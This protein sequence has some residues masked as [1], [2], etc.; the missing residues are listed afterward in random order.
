MIGEPTAEQQ[1]VIDASIDAGTLVLAGPGTGKTHTLILRLERMVAEERQP[2]VLS[3]TRSVVRE[4]H[5]RLGAAGLAARYLRPVTFDSM[6]TR[7]LSSVPELAGW[8]GWES[9]GYEGRIAAAEA[10]IEQEPAAR[11]WLASRFDHVVVDEVQDL[12]GR[13]GRLVLKILEVMPG[14]TL[15]GDPAQGIYGWQEDTEGLSADDFLAAVHLQH[16]QCLGTYE[17]TKNHRAQTVEIRELADYRPGL[18]DL[19]HA[20][21]ERTALRQRLQSTEPL[22]TLQAAAHLLTLYRGRTAVLCRTNVEA[23]IV[24]DALFAAGV[25]HVLRRSATDRAVVPWIAELVAGR[26]GALSRRGFIERYDAAALRDDLGADDAWDL[27]TGVSGEDDRV[28]LDRLADAMRRGSLPDELQSS[29]DGDLVVSTIHRAKGL[30]FDNVAIVHPPVWRSD[31][32]PAEDARLLFVAMTRARCS[33]AQ[34]VQISTF[35]WWLERSLDRWVRSTPAERWKTLGFELRGDDTHHMHPAG[36]YLFHQSAVD[37][38][39]RLRT[40]VSRGDPVRLQ[41]ANSD[42]GAE[43][44]AT[45]VVEH[46]AGPIGVTSERFGRDLARRLGAKRNTANRWPLTITDVRME[47]VD[48]VAGLDGVGQANGLGAS[49]IWLRARVVGLGQVNWFEGVDN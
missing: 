37:V 19:D 11:E 6:A 41:L 44:S 4:L 42:D 45:Y 32:N 48:S 49:G 1:A 27:L 26:R 29:R 21:D 23:L 17:L 47:G 43:P 15:L 36:T 14:F 20:G 7:L 5:T 46:A 8:Q 38:Q 34:I 40:S 33:L 2:L 22:G 10:A 9:V 12:V 24:S 18:M 31:G 35:R 25:D 16:A 30:E 13:R 39:D 3:F 28:P